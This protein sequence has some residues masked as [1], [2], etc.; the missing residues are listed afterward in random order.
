MGPQDGELN[1]LF[2]DSKE[3]E[4][5]EFKFYL[6]TKNFDLRSEQKRKSIFHKI[7]AD[8]PSINLENQI[9]QVKVHSYN[10]NKP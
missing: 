9:D 6:I 7:F 1:R 2:S 8:S 5:T 10:K 3:S 4:G